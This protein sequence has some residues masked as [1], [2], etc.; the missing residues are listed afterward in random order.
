MSGK[1]TIDG[2]GD[3]SIVCSFCKNLKNPMIKI[4]KAFPKKIPDVVWLGEKD[5]LTPIPGDH[6]IQY[7]KGVPGV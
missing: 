3:W 4:C 1:N 7:E 5:H 6:G 2:L